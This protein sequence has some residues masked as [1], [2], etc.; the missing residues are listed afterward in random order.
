MS[1]RK[2]ENNT[3]FRRRIMAAFEA[4]L[5]LAPDARE[6]FLKQEFGDDQSAIDQVKA[7]IVADSI[8]PSAMP[9]E[10]PGE[11]GA[12]S[13]LVVPERIGPYKL[14]AVLGAGGMGEVWLG[15]RDDGLFEQ[16]VAIKLMRPSRFAAES[17][18]FFDTERRALARL[19][20]RH[21]ARLYD[22]GV[23][24]KGLP[25]F[26]M[27]L[28][29]GLPLNTYAMRG[30]T[31][32]ASIRMIAAI[33]EAVQFAHSQLVVHADLKPSNILIKPDGEPVLVDFG[34]ASMAAAAAE[35]VQKAAFPSTPAYA[36]PQRL[37]GA[38]PIVADDVYGLGLLLHGLLTGKWP[39]KPMTPPL[40]TTA[41]A[42]CDAIIAKACAG[43]PGDRY[44][45]AQAF[46]D[47]LHAVLEDRPTSLELGDWRTESR[48]FV[49]RHPRGVAA[50]ASAVVGVVSAL[51]VIA[52][53]Y[54]HAN[55]ER[56][57]AQARFN[58]VREMANY[59]LGDFHEELVKLPGSA[60]LRERNATLGWQYLTKLSQDPRAPD[61]VTRDIAV[62][63][64]RLGNAQA[65]TSSNGSGEVKQGEE[66]LQKSETLLRG[67]LNKHP[68]RDD[69]RRELARTLAWRSG[70]LLGA[71][72]DPKAARAA[73]DESF[74]LFD[75]VLQ[76]NPKDLDA[77]YG[78]WNAVLG[79]GDLY[80][81]AD[82]MPS[83][84]AL[85]ED[86]L[87][88]FRDT[89]VTP[90][91]RSL[92]A[93]LEAGTENNLGDASYYVVSPAAGIAHYRRAEALMARARA[94]G[95]T[96]MRIPLRQ[97]YYNYQLSSSY[98]DQNQ[99]KPALEWA[100][101][102]LAV[103]A[104]VAEFD[105]S[106]ATLHT[107]DILT[108]QRSLVL[109][110]L[111]RAAEAVKAA[112]GSITRRRV[113]LSRQPD[114]MDNRVNLAAGLHNLAKLY[115]AAGDTRNA[116]DAA[117][118]SLATFDYVDKHGG[119]PER[120]RKLNVAPEQAFVAKCPTDRK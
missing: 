75:E 101:R 110:Q 50:A 109:A 83:L 67:L 37:Q 2:T 72:N 60:A 92:R 93:L 5:D 95:V 120:N 47:D 10:L 107:L 40:A 48:L 62:G 115:V 84:K 44:F 59:M 19:N 49:R 85:M 112:Q 16:Q 89:P 30:L 52:G 20:H 23:T 116:C 29:D 111:G 46:A 105:D 94:D 25:W 18:R 12:T 4:A 97:A 17:E 79:L 56:A 96:D 119:V 113:R 33:A 104:E 51:A 91:Y 21:I 39:E 54:V 77:A 68:D 1:S 14:E 45:S 61:D 102:G 8:A 64:S 81:G 100:D 34:I 22:G 42:R 13:I 73:L 106:A 15:Q 87:T 76:R 57:L 114:D 82:D 7:L 80:F 55:H 98:A 24:D 53:L 63:Y 38:A 71:H 88:R 103:I 86:T 28:I 74:R 11:N 118:E 70:V 27:E 9:T 65:T 117:R 99:P 78:R 58:D 41:D 26:V 32:E 6:A 90:K 69:Y 3:A 36:S 66:A 43:E 31:R 108:T 35:Q